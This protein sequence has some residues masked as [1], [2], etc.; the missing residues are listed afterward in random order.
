MIVGIR[1]ESKTQSNAN[2]HV[3]LL[4][5][6]NNWQPIEMLPDGPYRMINTEIPFGIILKFSSS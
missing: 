4:S 3:Q 5:S 6:H 1:L 2:A